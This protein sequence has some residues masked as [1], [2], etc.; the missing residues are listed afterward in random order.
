M[1]MA[2][3]RAEAKAMKR[4]SGEG[5]GVTSDSRLRPSLGRRSRSDVG[6]SLLRSLCESSDSRFQQ[7]V[8]RVR[9]SELRDRLR[10]FRLSFKPVV[11][12]RE[13]QQLLGVKRQAQLQL[14]GS[15]HRRSVRQN[16]VRIHEMPRLNDANASIRPSQCA[17]A[18][19]SPGVE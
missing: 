8:V 15:Y 11:L 5:S 14:L 10:P 2:P 16:D 19:R 4:P 18:E 9:A 6:S 12:R 3:P 13:S 1:E 7:T 17:R